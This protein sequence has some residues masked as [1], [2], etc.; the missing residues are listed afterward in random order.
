MT[1]LPRS[2]SLTRHFLIVEP[3]PL[4]RLLLCAALSGQFSDFHAVASFGEAQALL[5]TQKFTAIIAERHLPG[6]TALDL[7]EQARRTAS[8]VPF[9]LVCG[10]D[11][12]ALN[13]AHFRFF[14]K[15]FG[16]TEFT[17]CLAEMISASSRTRISRRFEPC[18]AASLCR[19]EGDGRDQA[20]GVGRELVKPTWRVRIHF[21]PSLEVREV[22]HAGR[23]LPPRVH[24]LR[25]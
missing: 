9:L 12:V 4:F 14:A 11:P 19:C 18:L 10:G 5:A 7:Y 17:D 13:D 15:P 1:Y 6:G 8:E 25:R 16:L 2:S 20:N 24:G 3:D 23:G 21:T 22:A